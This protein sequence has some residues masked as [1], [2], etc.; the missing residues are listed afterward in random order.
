MLIRYGSPNHSRVKE[1]AV[2]R[3]ATD[4]SLTYL[5]MLAEK[6][7]NFLRACL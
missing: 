2:V 1:M 6:L 3:D 7:V 5:N 4:G